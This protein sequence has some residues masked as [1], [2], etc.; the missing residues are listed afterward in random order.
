MPLVS[1]LP[2]EFAAGENGMAA[3]KSGEFARLLDDLFQAVPNPED[4]AD[5]TSAPATI[6]FDYLSVVEELHSGRIKVSGA[7]ATAEYRATTASIEDALR[8]IELKRAEIV[9]PPLAPEPLPSIEPADI[10]RELGLTAS[11][12]TDDLA[13]IRRA[14]AFEN[15][16]DRVAPQLRERAIVRMQIANMLVDEALRRLKR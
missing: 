12:G 11:A 9:P 14:F 2:L 16:P 6:P 5:A 4:T 13:R 7:E 10:A 1:G 3:A 15:H 8:E